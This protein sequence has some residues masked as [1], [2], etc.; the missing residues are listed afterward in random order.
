MGRYE[1]TWRVLQAA[2]G[3]ALLLWTGAVLVLVP[4]SRF[5]PMGTGGTLFDRIGLAGLGSG[6]LSG[7]TG[8][9]LTLSTEPTVAWG[10]LEKVTAATLFGVVL[11]AVALLVLVAV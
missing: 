8:L 5:V 6:I 3:M 11:L 7:L 10:R 2:L 1:G 9:A 4:I